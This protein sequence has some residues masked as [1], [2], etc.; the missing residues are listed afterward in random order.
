VERLRKTTVAVVVILFLA[1]CFYLGYYT[2]K[3]VNKPKYQ[4]VITVQQES[5]KDK[6]NFDKL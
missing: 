6:L 3:K 2:G 1:G 4:H 5:V